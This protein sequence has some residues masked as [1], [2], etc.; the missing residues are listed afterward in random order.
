MVP[1]K[2][3]SDTWK[4]NLNQ[5]S[6]KKNRQ[7]INMQKPKF[8]SLQKLQTIQELYYLLTP[9]KMPISFAKMLEDEEENKV[10]LLKTRFDRKVN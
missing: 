10:K 8:S 1:K 9:F 2:A 3:R 5:A 7:G 4:E 6:Q